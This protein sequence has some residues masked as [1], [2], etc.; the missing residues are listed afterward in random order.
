[1]AAGGP[2]V[3]GHRAA[4]ARGAHRLWPPGEGKSSSS[5]AG[6]VY[7]DANNNGLR[8]AGEAAIPGV[9]VRRTGAEKNGG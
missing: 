3:I 6:Y 9:I 1:M 2:D 8:D 4:A 5:L 7:I